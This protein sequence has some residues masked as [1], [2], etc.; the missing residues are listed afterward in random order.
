[1]RFESDFDGQITNKINGIVG[2][3]M[4]RFFYRDQRHADIWP[5][6]TPIQFLNDDGEEISVR[7]RL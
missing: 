4:Y 2:E 7:Y 5:K 1:M 6:N 3:E